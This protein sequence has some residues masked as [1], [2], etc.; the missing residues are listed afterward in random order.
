MHRLALIALGVTTHGEQSA[1]ATL[2]FAANV[3]PVN[4]L[5]WEQIGDVVIVDALAFGHAY[6]RA[7]VVDGGETITATV[8]G[9]VLSYPETELANK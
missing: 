4:T 3:E 8:D 6:H 9:L 1:T 7:F 2:R 5:A